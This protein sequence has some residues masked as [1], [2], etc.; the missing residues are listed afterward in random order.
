LLK[1]LR[2]WRRWAQKLDDLKESRSL[3]ALYE[4]YLTEDLPDFGTE[5]VGGIT[6]TLLKPSESRSAGPSVS[7][8]A[9]GNTFITGALGTLIAKDIEGYTTSLSASSLMSWYDSTVSTSP[10]TGTWFPASAPVIRAE[11]VLIEGLVGTRYI[12]NV[13]LVQ[14]T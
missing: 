13:N 9:T 1:L 14:I 6:L 12:V 7:L 8:T 5:S 2:V 11:K 3:L 4:R 10:G